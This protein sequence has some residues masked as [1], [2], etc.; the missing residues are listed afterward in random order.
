VWRLLTIEAVWESRIPYDFALL[1]YRRG[2][3]S[4]KAGPLGG[5]GG[6][7]PAFYKIIRNPKNKIIK[8]YPNGI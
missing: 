1:F 2:T 8:S 3:N 7:G 4:L 6:G 5:G